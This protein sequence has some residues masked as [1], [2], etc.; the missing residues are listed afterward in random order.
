MNDI[1]MKPL[2]IA[3]AKFAETYVNEPNQVN[4]M[5]SMNN[6]EYPGI[7][8]IDISAVEQLE[9]EFK[10]LQTDEKVTEEE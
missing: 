2:Q 1:L 3:T 9:E 5:V 6:K 7:N 4:V 8:G 10:F